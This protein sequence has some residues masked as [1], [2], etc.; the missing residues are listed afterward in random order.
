MNICIRKV[1]LWTIKTSKVAGGE[2]M[3]D[4]NKNGGM[5]DWAW[6][7]VGNYDCRDNFERYQ[8]CKIIDTK[9]MMR[10]KTAMAVVMM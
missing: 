10:E 9:L 5:P 7:Y 1:I 8:Y 2:G 6:R 4:K 3:S